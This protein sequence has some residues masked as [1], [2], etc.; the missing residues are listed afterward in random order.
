MAHMRDCQQPRLH[1]WLLTGYFW[2]ERGVMGH[3]EHKRDFK[4]S[5]LGGAMLAQLFLKREDAP[6]QENRGWE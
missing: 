6:A 1:W 5:Y 3:F 4:A 2:R